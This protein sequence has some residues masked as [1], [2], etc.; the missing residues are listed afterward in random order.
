MTDTALARRPRRADRVLTALRARVASGDLAAGARLPTE[1]AL[2]AEFGVS[3][4]VVR[5][6]VAVLAADG[7]VEPRQ[8]SGVFVTA[9]A[10]AG[11][12]GAVADLSGRLTAVLDVLEVRMAV[13]IEAAALAAQRRSAAGEA[14]IREAFAGLVGELEAGRPSGDADF[15]FHRAIAAATSNPFY[16]E[17]LD[18]LG[19]R[20][21]PRDLVAEAAPAYTASRAF[22][23]A[24]TAEHRAIL[25]AV[26][27][28]DPAAARDA[29]RRH[30]DASRRRYL[31][32]FQAAAGARV[33]GR[34][35]DDRPASQG[36]AG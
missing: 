20:T 11:L 21:I 31:D 32:L 30:L 9:R 6:A 12:A 7:L 35:R 28:A 15:A 25:D 5:E 36:V 10:G 2:V 34:G 18:V 13:E 29:M 23:D 14:A 1:A 26:A 8:G 33:S 4:S 16:V 27:A 3:R 22:V 19:R 24:L 17:T